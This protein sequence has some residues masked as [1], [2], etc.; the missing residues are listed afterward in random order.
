MPT[1]DGRTLTHLHLQLRQHSALVK[2]HLESHVQAFNVQVGVAR[3][4]G[5]YREQIDTV[6]RDSVND[7]TSN[8]QLHCVARQLATGLC[9]AHKAASNKGTV[10]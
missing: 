5:G 1:H 4:G 10:S 8:V 6:T 9:G 7:H 3:K 2:L